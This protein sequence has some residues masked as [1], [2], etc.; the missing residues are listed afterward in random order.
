[1]PDTY[2]YDDDDMVTIGVAAQ[3]TGYAAKTLRRWDKAGNLR[4]Q[5][6]PAGRRMYRVGDLRAIPRR[7]EPVAEPNGS[8]A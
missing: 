1:M 6:T 2:G 8:A 3:I 7:A 4:V 5:R